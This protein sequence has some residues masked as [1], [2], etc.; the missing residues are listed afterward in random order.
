MSLVPLKLHPGIN[1]QPTETLNELGWSHSG[2]IRFFQGL[3]Q[4]IG[5]F[6]AFCRVLAGAGTVQALRAWT[7][8]SQISWLGMGCSKQL[9]V[10]GGDAVSDITPLTFPAPIP[11]LLNTTAGSQIV[12]FNN[13]INPPTAGE[14]FQLQ[15]PISVGGIVLSGSYGVVSTAPGQF[16]I[17]A[18]TEATATVVNGGHTRLFTTTAGSAVVNVNLPDHSIFTGEPISIPNPVSVGG[19]TLSGNYLASAV[20]ANNYTITASTPATSS[21][22][23][24]ENGNQILL[25][26]FNPAIGGFQADMSVSTWTLDNWGEFL[27]A[28]PAGGPI[29]V[30]QPALGTSQPATNVTTAPQSNTAIFIATQQQQLFS[31]GSV[32]LA[33]GIF[34]PMLIRWSDAG[35]YTNFIPATNNQAGSF[36]L[37]SGSRIVG[38]IPIAG[39]ILIWTDRTLYYG[40]YLGFPLIWGFQPVGLNCGLI[41][42]HAFGTLAQSVFWESQLQFYYSTGGQP[43]VIPC[44]V[45]D[46]VFKN[47]D[48]A[49]AAGV[50][51]ESNSYFNEISW[52]VPQTDGTTVRAKLQIDSGEWDYTV[53]PSGNFLPRTAWIDQSVFGPPL[54]GDATGQIWQHEVGSDAGTQPLLWQLI[55]GVVQI[56]EGDQLTFI[57][58]IVPDFKFTADGSPGPGVV[59][60]LVYVWKTPQ[61][62]PRIKGP[63]PITS[64]TRSVRCKGRGWGL[65]FEFR[66]RGLNGFARLGDIRYRGAPDGRQ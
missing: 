7:A 49:N 42:S 55:S 40:Q 20:D 2:N 43:Q 34:D 37:S 21:A 61:D 16:T 44:A 23:V 53:L 62:P 39:G 65:Q 1:T 46:R 25:T 50:T 56:A 15:A 33:N 24:N 27:I 58:R 63:F 47:I 30:W 31:C 36:R 26:F 59:E 45:W 32:N 52:E 8:L 10:F 64:R 3:P 29:F 22:S 48:R 41:G 66:G 57:Q 14:W 54:A 13:T 35:D 11:L 5:G 38:G 19:L 28:C 18:A 60:M 12:T 17:A 4:T 9:N 51:C 6:V